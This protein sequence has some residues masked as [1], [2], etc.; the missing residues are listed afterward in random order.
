MPSLR[1]DL[2]AYRAPGPPRADSSVIPSR[3]APFQKCTRYYW[4]EVG[5]R[6]LPHRL[7]VDSQ[8]VSIT[9]QCGPVTLPVLLYLHAPARLPD[10]KEKPF[11]CQ[12]GAAFTRRDLL[13]RHQRIALHQDAPESPSGP[14]EPGPGEQQQHH[15]PVDADLAAAVS[16]SG[17]SV[18]HW[19]QHQ[20][21]PA[22]APPATL[23]PVAVSGNV[24]L[25]DDA[26]YQQGLLAEPFYESGRPPTPGESH[27]CDCSKG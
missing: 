15:G 12:C 17:M 27:C 16:L 20:P 14:S 24:T 23:Y 8:T 7:A 2:Q 11:I 3:L 25:V 19:S 18:H 5:R 4:S 1:P 9:C 26:P 13:T 6:P 22:P 10:T 21:P